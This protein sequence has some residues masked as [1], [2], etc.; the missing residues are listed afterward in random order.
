MLPERL[1][2]EVKLQA[3]VDSL[4]VN[5]ELLRALRE[6]QWRLATSSWFELGIIAVFC[7]V[8]LTGGGLALVVDGSEIVE[9]IFV[10]L[11]LE[12]TKSCDGCLRM[13]N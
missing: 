2:Q 5:L 4:E 11:I 13:L 12:S 1:L 10:I 3:L 9:E 7:S 8:S 6:A